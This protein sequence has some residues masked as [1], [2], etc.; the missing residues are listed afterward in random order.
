M[1]VETATLKNGKTLQFNSDMIGDGAMKE[2]YFTTDRKKV[3]CFFKDPQAGSDR[4]RV[5][6]LDF[7]LGKYNPTLPRDAGGAASSA[8][9]AAFYSNLF[10]W[11]TDIVT[12]PRFGI[13]TATYPNNFFFETGPDFIKGKEKNG[14]RFLGRRNRQLLEKLAPREL[15][16]WINYFKLCITMTRAVARLHLAGLSHSDLSPNNVLVD[17][18]GGSSIVIDIDSLVVPGLFPP[19]VLGT[20]GYIA[21]EVLSTLPLKFDD[22]KR[23][24]PSARTDEHALAVLIYQY[25]LLRHPLDGR[26]IPPGNTAEEQDALQYGSQAIFCE[27]PTDDSNRVEEPNS[28]PNTCLG[29]LLP[30]LFKR[31][32]VDGLHQPHRRPSANEWLKALIKTWDLLTPCANAQCPQKWHV[33][34]A[35]KRQCPFCGTVARQPVP[36]LRLRYEAKPGQWLADGQL[37]VYDK[38]YLMKWH[39]FARLFPGPETDRTPQGYFAWHEGQWLLINQNLTSLTTSAGNRVP[40]GQAVALTHGSQIRLSQEPNGRIVEVQLQ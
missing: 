10:C 7:I 28:V 33:F 1:S 27:H 5:Q 40:P 20:K 18:V 31:A 36:V 30:D 22:P 9:D 23:Q 13:V 32:F 12:Q 38:L 26:R 4:L 14:V 16:T 15:G 2:V 6:R 34:D 19:D 17:P 11:P 37:V 25:L 3:V 24:H 8:G 29:P 35:Q 39:A 21:P